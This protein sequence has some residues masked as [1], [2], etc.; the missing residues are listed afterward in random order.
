M[1]PIG[2][3]SAD[4]AEVARHAGDRGGFEERAGHA[5]MDGGQ[6][7]VADDLWR[8]RHNQRAI[9]A[10]ADAETTRE[11]AFGEWAVRILRRFEH[12]RR[13]IAYRP[14]GQACWSGSRQ[15]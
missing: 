10:D 14:V 1:R 2:L 12:R 15:P 8:E 11:G 6:D 4:N 3:G 5:A 13:A 9:L 7:R